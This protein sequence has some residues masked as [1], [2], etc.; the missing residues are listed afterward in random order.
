MRFRGKSY[1]EI[2]KKLRVSKSTLNRWLEKIELTSLQKTQILKG[3]E[4]SRLAASNLK[5]ADRLKRTKEMYQAGMQEFLFLSKKSLF[6]V[7]LALYWAEGDKNRLERVKF[8]NSDHRLI[9][10]MMR[11]FREICRVPENKFRIALHIHNL[12]MSTEVVDYW[13]HITNISEKQFH[14]PYVKRTSLGQRKNILYNGTC[15]II[16]NSKDLFRRITGW[17][18]ALLDEFLPDQNDLKSL[19]S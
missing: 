6:K 19:L 12:H 13:K 4:K 7:G 17:K 8:T 5:K 16:I 14:R 11:W 1:G 10:L 18:I 2:R 3:L 15:S 9:A